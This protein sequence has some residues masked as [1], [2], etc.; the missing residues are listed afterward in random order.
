MMRTRVKICGLRTPEQVRMVAQAGADA[1]GF[2]LYPPS[3]R[4]VTLNE[5]IRLQAACPAFV[6]TVALL[7]NASH[8]EVEQVIKQLRPSL[9]QFHGDETP[10]FCEQFAYPYIRALP[11]GYSGG[12]GLSTA[13]EITETVLRYPHAKA[14]IFD[15]PSA[16]YGGTGQTF[17]HDLLSSVIDVIEPHR[18]MVAGGV[19]AQ[20]L[21]SIVQK[22]QPYAV[23]LSS[24]VEREKGVKCEQKLQT[25]MQAVRG[26]Q[27]E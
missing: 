25:F 15:T 23:D 21:A 6:S 14:F 12:Y 16:T 19:N 5:A 27:T 1:I 8:D 13:Q 17:D 22:L 10:E 9:I 26:L 20:N 24:A 18:R 4:A 11:I 2:V 3:P 7:V